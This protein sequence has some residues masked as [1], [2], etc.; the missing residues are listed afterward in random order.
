MELSQSTSDKSPEKKLQY[1]PPTL[2][3]E[4]IINSTS[5]KNQTHTNPLMQQ[6]KPFL[7]QVKQRAMN[8]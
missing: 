1:N 6:K 7:A 5:L 2:N 4:T 8:S 3:P